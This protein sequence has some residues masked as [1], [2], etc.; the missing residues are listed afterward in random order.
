MTP[1]WRSFSELTVTEL[2]DVMAL[3]QRVFVVEQNCAYLD[4]DGRDPE[5][6]HLLAREDAGE[7]QLSAYLRVFMPS[8][9]RKEAMV[10]RVVTTPEARGRGLARALM[11]EALERIE[12]DCPGTRVVISAQCYL[13]DFYASLGFTPVGEEYLEDGIPHLQMKKSSD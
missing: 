10:G 12:T 8:M 9:E 3:R 1:L 5:A 2:Y 13:K 6:L 4:A 7:L 11:L